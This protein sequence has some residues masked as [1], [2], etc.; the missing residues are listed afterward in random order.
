MYLSAISIGYSVPTENFDAS[1][2]SAFQSALNL[3]VNGD[4]G[5]LTLIESAEGDLPQGIQLDTPEGFS[6]EGFHTGQRALCRD[7]ILHFEN[8]SLAIQLNGA[9]RWECDLPALKF[10]PTNPAVSAAWTRV[11]EALNKRQRLYQADIIAEELFRSNEST[12]A[13]VPRRVGEAMRD[14]LRATRR[15]EFDHT[16]TVNSLIGLGAGLTPSG[17]DLLVG[18]LAGLWCTVQDGTKRA[19]FISSLGE[20]IIH[21][22]NKTNDISRTYLYHAARGQVSSRLADLAEAICRGGHPR[23]LL[24]TAETAMSVGHTSGMDAVSGLMVALSAWE[25]KEFRL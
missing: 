3:R 14:L 8:R 4:D 13:G 23:H 9:R 21:L 6:F 5:L 15:Y 20:T 1:V 12:R 19:Q 11:W 22:S 24:E 16:S 17:D 7:G 25:G 10:D 18:Y 2:H